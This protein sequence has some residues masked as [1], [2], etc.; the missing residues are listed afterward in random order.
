MS[1]YSERETV[2]LCALALE[3]FGET[4][5]ADVLMYESS[6]PS[7]HGIDGIKSSVVWRASDIPPFGKQTTVVQ[8]YTSS[9]IACSLKISGNP[10][11]ISEPLNSE[12]IKLNSTAAWGHLYALVKT[13][14]GKLPRPCTGL[15][16][17]ESSL[18]DFGPGTETN[19]NGMPVYTSG[20][21]I[22]GSFREG[23]KTPLA[24][25]KECDGRC[26]LTDAHTCEEHV[27]ETEAMLALEDYAGHIRIAENASSDIAFHI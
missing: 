1:D 19:V 5:T 6:N 27:S 24:W 16:D 10:E 13:A 12:N 26:Y 14:I 25:I 8:L 3:A 7:W 11:D 18:L 9:G 4:E 22:A 21:Y 20:R 17:Y 23:E 2:V 15:S